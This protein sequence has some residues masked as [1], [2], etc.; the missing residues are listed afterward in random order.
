LSVG[1]QKP[2]S[3]IIFLFWKRLNGIGVRAKGESI[4]GEIGS[5]KIAVFTVVNAVGVIVDRQGEIVRG[6]RDPKTG[7]RLSP[8]EGLE[9]RLARGEVVTTAFGNT[10]LTLVVTNQCLRP[11]ELRQLGRQVHCSMARA[12]QP[13]QTIN[14]GDVLY[15][16]TTNEV[17][18]S[19]VSGAMLGILA[20]E[21][22][23]DAVLKSIPE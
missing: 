5:T 8:I 6:N 12:I 15:T 9:Q 3:F 7:R 11:E 10:T 1:T 21:V 23:W 4:Q 2:V 16:V 22:A 13:F 19:P 14:D 18:D 20:S 17:D